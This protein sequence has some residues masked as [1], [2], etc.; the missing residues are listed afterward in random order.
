MDEIRNYLGADSIGYLDLQGM[1]GAT[2]RPAETF[3]T[4][5]FSGDY[6]VA[7]DAA[8]DKFIMEKRLGRVRLS[9]KIKRVCYEN[10]PDKGV[11]SGRRRRR[12]RQHPQ[13]RHPIDCPL[14]PR[15]EVLGKI[16][17]IWRTL[18]SGFQRNEGPGPG[19]QC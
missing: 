9:E 3:C 2:G 15:P 19:V 12:F 17:R 8:F 7:Y 11:R 16:R 1:I 18:P 10:E 5:C 14:N 13:A 6:P 4:A